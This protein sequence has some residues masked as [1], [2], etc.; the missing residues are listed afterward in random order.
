MCLVEVATIRICYLSVFNTIKYGNW[1][2]LYSRRCVQ[3]C[4]HYY[5]YLLYYKCMYVLCSCARLI[6]HKSNILYSL[7]VSPAMGL[8]GAQPWGSSGALLS[9]LQL[10][11]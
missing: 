11:H 3:I 6:L 10:I 5:I 2:V 9:D 8:P 1:R 7:A 4:V